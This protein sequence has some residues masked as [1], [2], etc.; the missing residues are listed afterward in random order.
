MEVRIENEK[1]IFC[2]GEKDYV[3]EAHGEMPRPSI[4]P[5]IS[6]GGKHLSNRDKDIKI[7]KHTAVQ[8]VALGDGKVAWYTQEFLPDEPDYK[9]SKKADIYIGDL[10]TGEEIHAYKG[11]CY[12]DLY[13]YENDLFFN[14]GNKVAVYHIDSGETEV[15]FKH[16]GIKKSGLSLHVTP[17]RIFFQHWTHSTNNTMWYDRE[18]KEIVNPHFDGGIQCFIDD[19][20]IIYKG[21]YQTWVYDVENKKKKQFFSK[22]EQ[23]NIIDTVAAFFDVPKEYFSCYY[24]NWSRIELDHMADGRIYFTCWLHY[25][26]EHT[27]YEQKE[28]NCHERGLASCMQTTISC[29]Y[30]KKDVRIEADKEDIVCEEKPYTDRSFAFPYV[31]KKTVMSR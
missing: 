11:E 2:D 4:M 7:E 1:L 26:E 3:F 24:S 8:S 13:F 10:T 21:L 27:S 16:S 30:L 29:G 12:G 28:I 14:Q 23:N 20:T 9:L 6:V 25:H 17:K 31:I 15:L 19:V 22:K 5:A 18:T